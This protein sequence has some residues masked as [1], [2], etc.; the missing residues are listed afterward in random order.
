[1]TIEGSQS[2]ACTKDAMH[3]GTVNGRM[4]RQLLN[5]HTIENVTNLT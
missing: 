2:L 5:Y 1:M 4:L 3:P